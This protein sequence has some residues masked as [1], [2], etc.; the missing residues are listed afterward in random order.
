MFRIRR[1]T[2]SDKDAWNRFVAESKNG[3]FLFDRNYMDYHSDR[4]ADFSFLITDSADRLIGVLPA[5]RR[6]D[7]VV[8]HGGLT[9]GGIV[10]AR[11]MTTTGMIDLF[12]ELRRH[13]VELGVRWLDYKTIPAIYHR[14]PA[15]EDRFVL[16]LNG[17]SLVRR[18]VLSVIEAGSAV[19]VQERRLRGIRK[20]EKAGV[21]IEPTHQYE[22]FWRVLTDN[23]MTAHDRQPVHSVEEITLLSR[24][25]PENI[26][27]FVAK[28]GDETLG[29]AVMYLAGRTAHAQYI[30][31]SAEGRQV[32]AL[33][34]LFM[35]LIE[36]FNQIRYFDFGISNE[37]DGRQFNRGLL[38]FKEGFGARAAVH[39]HY[40]LDLS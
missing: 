18:D 16:F 6:E 32:G 4:F 38:D 22:E 2:A 25:F 12:A 23:L 29:G 21:S 37:G 31:S 17:A 10:S 27:L 20:A 8:S 34:L 24:R 26:Q 30:A 40:C 28:R 14:L 5:N 9:Y 7:R 19:P 36:R 1:Y 35:R 3:T 39:D 11:D 33:D 15:E 13:L